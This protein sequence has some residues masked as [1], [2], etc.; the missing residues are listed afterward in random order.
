[1]ALKRPVSSS[2]RI[3]SR[4]GQSASVYLGKQGKHSPAPV[5]SW[6]NWTQLMY[7][8]ELRIP[9]QI[10]REDGS[11]ELDYEIRSYSREESKWPGCPQIQ[12]DQVDQFTATVDIYMI[13]SILVCLCSTM[14]YF[15]PDHLQQIFPIL[16]SSKSWARLREAKKIL[17]KFQ[18]WN[19]IEM[20]CL[21]LM[22]PH[23]QVKQGILV[24]NCQSPAKR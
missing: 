2:T 13:P 3:N 4:C 9:E 21:R 8:I 23:S 14:I 15:L 7:S 24:T 12:W 5:K 18:R 16:L 11:K 10:G 20:Q 22:F 1:V 17:P 19:L 6:M